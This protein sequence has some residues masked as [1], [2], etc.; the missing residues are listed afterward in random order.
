MA[1]L[2]MNTYLAVDLESAWDE[3]LY[4]D[5]RAFDRKPNRR[6]TAVDRITAA[7]VFEFTVGDHGEVST[8][9]V[10]LWNQHQW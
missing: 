1:K 6:A 3:K 8:G 2:V 4:G 5:H 9:A 7:A 10:S